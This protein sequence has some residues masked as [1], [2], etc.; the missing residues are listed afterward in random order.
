MF[1]ILS[2]RQKCNGMVHFK[3]VFLQFFTRVYEYHQNGGYL[4][5][6][7]K[8][9][10]TLLQFVFVVWF[11]TFLQARVDY[12]VLFKNKNISAEGKPVGGKIR[13]NVNFSPF[14]FNFQDSF[15][16]KFLWFI[17]LRIPFLLALVVG[18]VPAGLLRLENSIEI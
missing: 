1:T 9:I 17:F 12:D 15:Q 18:P 4:C 11:V 8:H 6:V 2:A 5:I 10:L 3:T 14:I 7:I 16:R 13:L